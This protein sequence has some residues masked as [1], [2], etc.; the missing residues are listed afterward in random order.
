M[1]GKKIYSNNVI[2]IFSFEKET[3]DEENI[4]VAVTGGA[5]IVCAYNT[6]EDVVKYLIEN[7]AYINKQDKVLDQFL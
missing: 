2:T 7:T 4:F 5:A 1:E 6:L 3:Q